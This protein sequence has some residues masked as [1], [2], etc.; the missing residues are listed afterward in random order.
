MF[1][2]LVMYVTSAQMAGIDT[3]TLRK[4][5]DGLQCVVHREL[6]NAAQFNLLLI[7]AM[8]SGKP[9]SCGT[10]A[11][12]DALMLTADWVAAE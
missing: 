12:L 8:M 7:I 10:A 5:N 9:F 6:V 3:Q 4:S 2:Y 11:D 1:D